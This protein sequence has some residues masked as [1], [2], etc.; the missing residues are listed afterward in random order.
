MHFLYNLGIFLLGF[1]IQLASFFSSKAKLWISGR[2]NW[3]QFYKQHKSTLLKQPHTLWMHVS[4]L[5][6]FEQGRPVLER[7]REVYPDFN[8]VLTFFSPSG[9]EIRK[10]YTGADLVG[11]LPLDTPKN[12][13]DFLDILQP[14]LAVFVKYDFW[15]NH[16]FAL[17]SRGVPTLLVAG[18]FREN[19]VYFKPLGAFWKNVLACF[20]EMH[21]QNVE[22]EKLLQGIGL[23]HITVAGDTRIDR[24][25]RLAEQA[26]APDNIAAFVH[27]ANPVIIAGSTWDPDENMLRTLILNNTFPHAKWIIAPHH[28]SANHVQK[29]QAVIPGSVRLSEL[30]IPNDYNKKVLII[31]NVGMLNSLY[32][33]A[34]IAYIGGGF[35]R[36]IHNTLEPAAFG[37]PVIFGPNYQKFEE[38]RQ[39]VAL[40]G[41]WSVQDATALLKAI[42]HF[43][44]R[45][46]RYAAQEAVLGYLVLSKGAT[47]KAVDT[48]QKMRANLH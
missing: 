6:E 5:G 22:S 15:A 35:G 48:L 40:G 33:L 45:E 23:H 1:A 19:Q 18:L 11:Y 28:P 46:K 12:A 32:K 20:S 10:Q 7:F 8:I 30:S 29:L 38:A 43:S 9:F 41:A 26:H 44:E 3:R 31:D 47:E 4:S 25:I 24:V 36:G 2:K 42:E 39:F 17:K 21:V 16:L 14:S 37:L 13:R 34:D 27:E